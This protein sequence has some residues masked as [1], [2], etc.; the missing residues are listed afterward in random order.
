[1]VGNLS[2]HS[3]VYPTVRSCA[4]RMTDSIGMHPDVPNL[5]EIQKRFRAN[6]SMRYVEPVVEMFVQ[7]LHDW[8]D[9]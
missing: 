6:R 8:E 2:L 4:A 5:A 7:E 3:V 9:R 1:M